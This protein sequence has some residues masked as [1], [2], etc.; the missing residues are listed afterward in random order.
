MA[1]ECQGEARHPAAPVRLN[2][3]AASEA[4]D[5]VSYAYSQWRKTFNDARAQAAW[6]RIWT[7]LGPR[8]WEVSIW[9]A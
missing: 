1:R 6:G 5:L 9:P 8:L 2:A 4:A 7:S 3:I